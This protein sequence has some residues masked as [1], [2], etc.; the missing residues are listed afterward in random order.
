[1]STLPTKTVTETKA[2]PYQPRI[3]GYGHPGYCVPFVFGPPDDFGH[4]LAEEKR[5]LGLPPWA[6]AWSEAQVHHFEIEGE[7]RDVVQTCERYVKLLEKLVS[8]LDRSGLLPLS[9]SPS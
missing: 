6:T 9:P 8:D 2:V 5:K 3:V 4:P 1:M 7:R